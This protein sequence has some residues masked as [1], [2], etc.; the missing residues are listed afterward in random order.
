M[1]KLEQ[2]L[3]YVLNHPNCTREECVEAIGSTARFYLDS[4]KG[5]VQGNHR[6]SYNDIHLPVYFK[7]Q[8]TFTRPNQVRSLKNTYTIS[9]RGKE[10][11]SRKFSIGIF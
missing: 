9:E 5:Y 8:K 2:L 11:L 1:T 7:V 6:Y 4:Y 3:Y 10:K